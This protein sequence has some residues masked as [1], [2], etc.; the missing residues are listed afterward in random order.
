ML[1]MFEHPQSL[2]WKPFCSKV[3]SQTIWDRSQQQ[4]TN[5]IKPRKEEGDCLTNAWNMFTLS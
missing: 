3:C 1:G 4:D 5:M 2:R